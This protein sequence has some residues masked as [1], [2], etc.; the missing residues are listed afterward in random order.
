MTRPTGLLIFGSSHVGKTTLAERIGQATAWP[1]LSSDKM[2]RHPG[3]PWPVVR[4]PVAEYYERL[5]D[6]TIY[7]F[8]RTHYENMWPLIG[9]AIDAERQAG[10][11]FVLEGSA[12][13]PDYLAM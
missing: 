6:E 10:R 4:A 3:R 13:R 5:T 12:L 2:A 11:H 1:V 9:R 7:W 8:L